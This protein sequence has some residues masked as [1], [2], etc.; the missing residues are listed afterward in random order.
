MNAMNVKILTTVKEWQN[1]SD[2]T[3]FYCYGVNDKSRIVL[4][5]SY[6]T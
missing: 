4:L 1:K 3:M 5:K 2:D 6:D